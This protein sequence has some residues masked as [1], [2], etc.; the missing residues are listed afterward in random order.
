MNGF[1]SDHSVRLPRVTLYLLH[2][3]FSSVLAS[4]WIQDEQQ[5][6]TKRRNCEEKIFKYTRNAN[7]NCLLML[8]L[9]CVKMVKSFLLLFGFSSILSFAFIFFAVFP[10]FSFPV[11]AKQKMR[12]FRFDTVE[13]WKINANVQSEMD[14]KVARN[15]F[16]FSFVVIFFFIFSF[17]RFQ[18]EKMWTTKQFC[19]KFYWI[20]DLFLYWKFALPAVNCICSIYKHLIQFYR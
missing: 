11:E 14:E 16:S 20:R 9:L 2:T 1:L 5:P 7:R 15:R 19:S 18:S 17:Y 10:L 4:L 12:I 6:N 13:N 3:F 8:L